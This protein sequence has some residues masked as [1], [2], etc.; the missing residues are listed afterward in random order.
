M[1]GVILFALS[2]STLMRNAVGR[3]DDFNGYAKLVSIMSSLILLYYVSIYLFISNYGRI[4]WVLTL[5]YKPRLRYFLENINF[6]YVLHVVN[7]GG[8]RPTDIWTFDHSCR[9]LREKNCILFVL[10][11]SQ[12]GKVSVDDNKRGWLL[13]C[14]YKCPCLSPHIFL[15]HCHVK[16]QKMAIY[17]PGKG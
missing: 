3:H 2:N 10:F 6:T 8:F 12:G 1:S 11:G 14:P 16:A 7:K 17:K 15:L 13:L 9:N 5:F 4:F